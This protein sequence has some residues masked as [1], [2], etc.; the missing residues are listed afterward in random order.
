MFPLVA[1]AFRLGSPDLACSIAFAV[2]V[3]VA[4]SI[5]CI[6]CLK[7]TL[8][9]GT[10]PA[11]LTA[12]PWEA[13]ARPARVPMAGYGSGAP[14]TRTRGAAA[15][16]ASSCRGGVGRPSVWS[17]QQSSRRSP[18]VPERGTAGR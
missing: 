12:W 10:C 6:A 17:V 2:A 14:R 8:P 16:V 18:A 15:A 1:L 13:R 4:A 11:S 3:N 5:A 9:E 7:Y